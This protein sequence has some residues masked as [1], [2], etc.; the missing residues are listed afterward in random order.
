MS[1]DRCQRYVCLLACRI[2]RATA[3]LGQRHDITLICESHNCFFYFNLLS[4]SFSKFP[5]RI[6][7]IDPPPSDQ[8]QTPIIT[9]KCNSSPRPQL[10][11]RHSSQL[12]QVLPRN[13]LGHAHRRLRRMRRPPHGRYTRMPND[14]K[15]AKLVPGT[16]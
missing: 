1:I 4:L 13:R 12:P 6:R 8:R 5:T 10:L 14:G 15:V 7:Q 3:R 2:L 16:P 11:P 9:R